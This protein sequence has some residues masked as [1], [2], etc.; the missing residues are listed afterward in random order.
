MIVTSILGEI[1]YMYVERIYNEELFFDCK[2]VCFQVERQL[3]VLQSSHAGVDVP[4]LEQDN[5]LCPC[6]GIQDNNLQQYAELPPR[7]SDPLPSQLPLYYLHV[8]YDES[9]GVTT[10]TT[11]IRAQACTKVSFH[12]PC[13]ACRDVRRIVLRKHQRCQVS[14]K[15][16]LS[17]FSPLSSISKTRLATA[18]KV[19]RIKKIKAQ[20]E[21]EGIR[22][23]LQKESVEVPESTHT[24]LKTTLDSCEMQEESFVKKFWEEQQNAFNRKSGGMRWH[25]MMVRFAILLHSQSPSSY[26]C[27]RELGVVKLPA[28]STLR[29]YTNVLHPQSGFQMEVFLDLKQETEELTDNQR[30][31]CLLHDELSIKSGLVYDRRSSELVGFIDDSYTNQKSAKAEHLATH[32]LVFMVIGVTGNIKRSLGYLPTRTATADQ[33]FPHLWTAVGLLESV[34]NLKVSNT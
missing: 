16:E 31:V 1:L 12:G 2:G 9:D 4:A 6:P 25:P 27:L 11:V 28:E 29:D 19:T 33:I 30:W 26:R 34:C 22:L 15:Q 8:Q 3:P 18:L 10:C 5:T 21:S 20:K 13:N 24:K 7:S 17:K 14:E 32:A 23:R